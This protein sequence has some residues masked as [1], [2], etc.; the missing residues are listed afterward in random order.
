MLAIEQLV[1]PLGLRV[2]PVLDLPPLHAAPVRIA[3]PLGDDA[4]EVVLFDRC[5]ERL[6]APLDRQRLGDEVIGAP[7]K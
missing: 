1:P 6:A 2:C 7:P 4:F 5:H 3:L